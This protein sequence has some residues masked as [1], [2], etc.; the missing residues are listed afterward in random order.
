MIW[1]FFHVFLPIW[2][3][4]H[5]SN[6]QGKDLNPH[7][8]SW[9]MHS[10]NPNLWGCALHL[11]CFQ[12]SWSFLGHGP[13]WQLVQFLW[14]KQCVQGIGLFWKRDYFSGGSFQSSWSQ[15]MEMR[16]QICPHI[17]FG[18]CLQN[19]IINVCD[20]LFFSNHFNKMDCHDSTEKNRKTA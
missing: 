1:I 6:S 20:V 7:A 5:L 9:R 3:E 13:F 15:A 11:F 18:F 10:R 17:S 4:R 19:D 2:M 16:F 8:N 12:G 14:R